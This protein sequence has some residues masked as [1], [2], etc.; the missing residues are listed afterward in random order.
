MS[1]L[2][3]LRCIVMKNV[4]DKLSG[5]LVPD[6]LVS[7]ID[8]EVDRHTNQLVNNIKNEGTKSN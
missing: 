7:Y 8:I 4:L 1:I 2:T 6:H 5:E 3:V